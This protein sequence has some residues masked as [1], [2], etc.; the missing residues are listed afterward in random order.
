M[1]ELK[2]LS[3][4]SLENPLTDKEYQHMVN[5]KMALDNLQVD[6]E[7]IR[8]ISDSPKR[9]CVLDEPTRRKRK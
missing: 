4:H 9:N 8:R 7:E 1:A 6:N 2:A 3:S 5:L